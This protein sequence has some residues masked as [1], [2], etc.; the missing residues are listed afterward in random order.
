MSEQFGLPAVKAGFA[1]G[2]NQAFVFF[3]R[4]LKVTK[5]TGS[6]RPRVLGY[7]MAHELGH[8]LLD[9][10]SHSTTGI[11]SSNVLSRD[12][13]DMM[14]LVFTATQSDHMHAQL[15]A[16]ILATKTSLAG[17]VSGDTN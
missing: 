16:E 9:G 10:E 3:D 17:A 12:C 4:V 2:P 8:L 14:L 5:D 7:V 15:Q 6:S 13:P 1:V 11:M